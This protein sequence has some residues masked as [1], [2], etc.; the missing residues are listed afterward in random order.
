MET[1]VG[2]LCP[3]P[4]LPPLPRAGAS[5]PAPGTHLHPPPRPHPPPPQVA[6]RG[7]VAPEPRAFFPSRLGVWKAPLGMIRKCCRDA[8]PYRGA[9]PPTVVSPWPTTPSTTPTSP[10][11]PLWLPPEDQQADPCPSSPASPAGP[12]SVGLHLGSCR[13]AEGRKE[14]ARKQGAERRMIGRE[15]DGLPGS[16]RASSCPVS[17]PKKGHRPGC[18]VIPG[19]EGTRREPGGR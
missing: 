11:G 15:G 9:A 13:A 16:G 1:E 2:P 6:S 12:T 14:G 10:A 18:G 5:L 8:R 7:A 3:P 19:G 4:C 17:C